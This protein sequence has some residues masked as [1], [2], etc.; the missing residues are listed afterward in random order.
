MS[1][2]ET[3]SSVAYDVGGYC[4]YYRMF[5]AEVTLK[6]VVGEDYVKNLSAFEWGRSSNLVYLLAY[7]SLANDR[8]ELDWFIGGLMEVLNGDMKDILGGK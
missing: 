3:K 8:G 6:D 1:V 2:M 5:V 4:R 7:M